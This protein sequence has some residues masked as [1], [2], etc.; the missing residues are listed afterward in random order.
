MS[1]KTEEISMLEASTPMV[2]SS[3]HRIMAPHEPGVSFVCPNCG[4]GVIK[5]CNKCR[6]LSIH[7]IC[8]V[9]GFRGP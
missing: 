7:Y 9:C 2:C 4:R 8:P 3:C 6:K 1:T 5:R